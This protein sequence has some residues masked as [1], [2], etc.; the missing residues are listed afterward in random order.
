MRKAGR[1]DRKSDAMKLMV[2]L[3]FPTLYDPDS[4]TLGIPQ[5]NYSLI[6]ACYDSGPVMIDAITALGAP[7]KPGGWVT[8]ADGTYGG[9][10]P[11]ALTAVASQ[12]NLPLKKAPR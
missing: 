5:L 10:P 3:S 8:N 1:T 9:P 4:P 12:L 7:Q 6:E 2:R 11:G